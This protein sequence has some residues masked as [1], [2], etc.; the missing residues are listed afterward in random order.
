MK[1]Y[2]SLIEAKNNELL[3]TK[4]EMEKVRTEFKEKLTLYTKKW[5]GDKAKEIITSNPVLTEKLGSEGLRPIK[6]EVTELI[7]STESIVNDY[8]DKEKL[9]WNLKENK[10]D[11]FIYGNKAPEILHAEIKFLF[12]RIGKIFEKNDYI[13]IY[14]GYTGSTNEFVL[15]DKQVHYNFGVM[16]KL[17]E[18]HTVL[19]NYGNLFK[20]AEQNIY[21]INSLHKEKEKNSAEDLW[22]SI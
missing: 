18:V 10:N 19:R 15:I 8:F 21:D 13:T 1:D 16:H 12:G 7:E 17:D 9:W 11:Y 3:I 14:S 20:K 2:D 4:A 5:F 22:D 6:E